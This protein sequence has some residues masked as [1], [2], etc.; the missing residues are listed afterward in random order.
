ME[1]VKGARL[2]TKPMHETI[3]IGNRLTVRRQ[4]CGR[5]GGR[6]LD[7]WGLLILGPRGQEVKGPNGEWELISRNA[8]G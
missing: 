1:G 6:K 3:W 7:C 5:K 2:E 4:R 8:C